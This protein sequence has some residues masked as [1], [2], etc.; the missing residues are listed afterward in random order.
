VAIIGVENWLVSM[1]GASGHHRFTGNPR[2]AI[3][4]GSA[5]AFL[6]VGVLATRRAAAA[7]GHLISARSAAAAGPAIRLITTAAGY[8]VVFFAVLGI[9]GIPVE[10]LLVGAGL[11][12]VVLGIAGQQTLGNVFAGMVLIVARPFTVGDHVRV[13]SGALGGIFDGDVMGMSLTY[14][15][16]TV[17]GVVV[18]IPNSGMLAA[19]VGRLS[20]RLTTV[21]GAVPVV[22]GASGAVPVVAGA[23]GAVPAVP[24][25][26][27][28][29]PG[30]AVAPLPGAPAP[31]PSTGAPTPATTATPAVVEA[32][33]GPGDHRAPAPGAEPGASQDPASAA[34]PASRTARR[35]AELRAARRR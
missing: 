18:K 33:P 32:V 34:V 25:Q 12:G 21:T 13:R 3:M 11:A 5:A 31:P 16:L 2:T 15:T 7:L 14:V 23:S 30:G 10:H 4:W 24:A 9:A 22:T 35:R 8:L 26:S 29:A 27:G 19:G 6:V 20:G 1:T 28:A 17:D